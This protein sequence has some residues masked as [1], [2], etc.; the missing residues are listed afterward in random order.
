MGSK[1][2]APTNLKY[3]SKRKALPAGIWKL[4]HYKLADTKKVQQSSLA[5]SAGPSG[6]GTIHSQYPHAPHEARRPVR[7]VTCGAASPTGSNSWLYCL[8]PWAGHSGWLCTTLEPSLVSKSYLL[9]SPPTECFAPLKCSVKPSDCF[10][11]PLE[12]SI[13]LP[14]STGRDIYH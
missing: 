11:L 6:F 1:S 12:A 14:S 7:A 10:E 8:T 13:P 9:R 3:L 4:T 2:P 5:P